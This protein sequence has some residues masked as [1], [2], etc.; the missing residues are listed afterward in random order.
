MV[1]LVFCFKKAYLG[2]SVLIKNDFS[3]FLF[4]IFFSFLN[5]RNNLFLASSTPKYLFLSRHAHRA[6][7]RHRSS[8]GTRDAC[9]APLEVPALP[10]LPWGSSWASQELA[11]SKQHQGFSSTAQA[12]LI[13][14]TEEVV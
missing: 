8:G 12:D 5:K 14:C 6:L 2:V 3:P 9:S 1:F 13:H 11:G 4:F 7:G 10:R